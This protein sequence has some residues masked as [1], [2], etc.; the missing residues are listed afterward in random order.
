MEKEIIKELKFLILLNAW[1]GIIS[2]IGVFSKNIEE[3]NPL[4]RDIISNIYS[5]VAVKLIMPTL[6]IIVIIF[7]IKSGV[8]YPSKTVKKLINTTLYLY[9]TVSFLHVLWIIKAII[10]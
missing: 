4:M 3:W 8:Y 1:D 7:L 2:Y 9:I 10:L 6:L 5:L